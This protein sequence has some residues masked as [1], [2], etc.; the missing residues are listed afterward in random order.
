MLQ[1]FHCF[2]IQVACQVAFEKAG[3]PY[4]QDE[5][6]AHACVGVGD[7]DRSAQ[8]LLERL[9]FIVRLLSLV[10][11]SSRI[12]H[13]TWVYI[14]LLVVFSNLGF[15]CRAS[16]STEND[17]KVS[18]AEITLHP[19]IRAHHAKVWHLSQ[20][21]RCD[22]FGVRLGLFLKLHDKHVALRLVGA[23]PGGFWE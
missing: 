22:G 7:D 19:T 6:G 5:G 1:Q 3:M 14:D 20:H 8:T 16:V 18:Y 2:W 15:R 4:H 21:G 11:K 13:F 17:V 10:R 9:N 23:W 12:V